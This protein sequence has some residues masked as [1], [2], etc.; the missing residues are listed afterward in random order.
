MGP[1]LSVVATDLGLLLSVVLPS[2]LGALG[3]DNGFG[4]SSLGGDGGLGTSSLG[5]SS[6]SYLGGDA[7]VVPLDVPSECC[8][9][10]L[11]NFLFVINVN[12]DI[13][14]RLISVF[15]I[16]SSLKRYPGGEMFRVFV[17]WDSTGM[18][19]EPVSRSTTCRIKT[20]AFFRSFAARSR[21]DHLRLFARLLVSQSRANICLELMC[22]W[23]WGQGAGTDYL[24]Y[25][26]F[27]FYFFS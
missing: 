6:T 14:Q 3:G 23:F 15:G 9:F 12:D 19:N 8:P 25:L 11:M 4:T 22:G 20:V 27:R 1:L 26:Y 18:I 5:G 16:K 13:A 10:K 24:F 21:F 2:Y 17:P 7:I